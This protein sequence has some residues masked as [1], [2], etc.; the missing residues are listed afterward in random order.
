LRLLPPQDLTLVLEAVELVEKD[1]QLLAWLVLMGWVVV[2]V[3]VVRVVAAYNLQ[4]VVVAT[5]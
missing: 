1:H 3:V 4:A 5:E 2:A